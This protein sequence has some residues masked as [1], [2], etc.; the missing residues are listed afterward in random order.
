MYCV[1]HNISNIHAAYSTHPPMG[2]WV[3]GVGIA[4]W[5]IDALPVLKYDFHGIG[6]LED[7]KY[8]LPKNDRNK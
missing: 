8:G 4:R 1:L 5:C 7:T 6:D 2:Q 3:E